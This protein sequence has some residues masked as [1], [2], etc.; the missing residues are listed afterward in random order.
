M[1]HLSN[2]IIFD[3]IYFLTSGAIFLQQQHKILAESSTLQSWSVWNFTGSS[4]V[5][6]KQTENRI[7]LLIETFQNNECPPLW[8]HFHEASRLSIRTKEIYYER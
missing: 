2:R 5:D 7:L 1:Q 3:D 6:V 4:S 8:H